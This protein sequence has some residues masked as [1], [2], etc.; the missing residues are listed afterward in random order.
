MVF[1]E[2]EEL[3]GNHQRD[4]ALPRRVSHFRPKSCKVTPPCK[5]TSVYGSSSNSGDGGGGGGGAILVV[6]L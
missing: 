1:S 6:A 4:T 5:V 2:T 3:P